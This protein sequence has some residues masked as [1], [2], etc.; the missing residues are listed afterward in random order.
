MTQVKKAGEKGTYQM[1]DAQCIGRGC[2]APGLYQHRGA[3]SSG[4]KNSGE[5]RRCI[6]QAYHGCPAVRPFLKML[7]AERRREGWKN[8]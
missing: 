6:H 3:T 2:F 1:L 8:V 7:A 4:S 5:S